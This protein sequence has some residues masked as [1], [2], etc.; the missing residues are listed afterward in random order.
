[1]ETLLQTQTEIN[2]K[3]SWIDD[4]VLVII[5]LYKNF[6]LLVLHYPKQADSYYILP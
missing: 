5:V 2:E 6:Q 4:D 3:K 1:M